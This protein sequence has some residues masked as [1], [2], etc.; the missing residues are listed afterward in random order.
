MR[1][2]SYFA[3][4]VTEAMNRA[5][6]ELGSDAMI[7]A[8]NR[9]SGDVARLGQY[10]VVFGVNEMAPPLPEE[11]APP[12]PLLAA[13][14]GLER[15]RERMEE[16]RKSVAKKREQASAARPA[17]IAPKVAA[18]LIAAG[19]P[20][21]AADELARVVQLRSR[22]EKSAATYALGE[23]LAERVRLNSRI[24]CGGPG[25]STVALVGPPGA[26]KTSMVVKLAVNYGIAMDRP[27]RLISTDT[28]RLGGSELLARY[29]RWMEIK[30]DLAESAESL[31]R[32]LVAGDRNE[33]LLIDTPGYGPAHFGSAMP[34]AG[35][36]SKR[37]NVDVHLVLPS[38]A[39]AA[40]LASTV[41]RFKPFL[42]SKLMF[43]GLDMCESIA[44]VL[45]LAVASELPVSFLS[46]GERV[47]ED[48][49]EAA[50]DGLAA[51]LLPVLME[52]AASAA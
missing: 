9:T 23:A 6:V 27:T 47:P 51:R 14:E 3:N 48:L 1:I 21:A 17:P 30:L 12:S 24:G 13:P 50:V 19:F 28:Y 29:A 35:V 34:I 32:L 25:R 45:A 15:L 36:L 40:T 18:S 52:A 46:V 5:R 33:L 42:P 4:S 10:E 2:K 39:S 43:A 7:I 26:G 41:E 44:P 38:Y 37:A 11:V 8:T 31:E 49:E 20:E 22:D 16:L